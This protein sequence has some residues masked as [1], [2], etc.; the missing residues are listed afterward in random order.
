MQINRLSQ[1]NER[2]DQSERVSAQ[3]SMDAARWV[4][5]D[6][7]A[8]VTVAVDREGLRAVGNVALA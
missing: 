4:G 1:M 3:V 2:A 7:T 5:S 6:P 8:G